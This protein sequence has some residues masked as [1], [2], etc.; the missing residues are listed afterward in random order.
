MVNKEHL[1]IGNLVHFG[2]DKDTVKEV[3]HDG[4]IGYHT[5]FTPFDRI[6]G[7]LL[8]IFSLSNIG[9]VYDEDKNLYKKRNVVVRKVEKPNSFD[10]TVTIDRGTTHIQTEVVFV[11]QIQNLLKYIEK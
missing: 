10:Y 3:W 8:D 6:D 1:N 9:F 11:H 2:Y 7:V 5:P 4:A